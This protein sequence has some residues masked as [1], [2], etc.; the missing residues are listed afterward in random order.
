M[1]ILLTYIF[2]LSFISNI[3]SDDLL[4]YSQI[5]NQVLFNFIHSQVS[6]L[7]GKR[8]Q[9]SAPNIER[10]V[11]VNE[12][13]II[14]KAIPKDLYISF[15]EDLN[16]ADKSDFR[17]LTIPSSWE[18]FSP[19][20][21]R[22]AIL[23]WTMGS[24]FYPYY[25]NDNIVKQ[26]LSL[27]E[28]ALFLRPEQ[29]NVIS[30]LQQV[31]E[32]NQK[33]ALVVAPTSFGKSLVYYDH[34]RM[35]LKEQN[36]LVH[37]LSSD[38]IG[39]VQ[40]MDHSIRELVKLYP[41]TKIVRWYGQQNRD[42][43]KLETHLKKYDNVILLTTTTSFKN[44][45]LKEKNKRAELI[46]HL[47]SWIYDEAHHLGGNQT[48]E[49]SHK[50]FSEIHTD[51]FFT[52]GISASPLHNKK[53]IGE[54]Y[55]N[56]GEVISAYLDLSDYDNMA[57]ALIDQLE[58]GM[59]KA[60]LPLLD[61]LYTFDLGQLNEFG[62]AYTKGR[63]GFFEI[64][65]DYYPHL[66]NYIN[67]VLE[68][69]KTLIT[70]NSIDEVDELSKYF[71][72]HVSGVVKLHSNMSEEQKSLAMNRI[73]KGDYQL[74]FSVNMLNESI[75]INGLR[76]L[77][78]FSQSKSPVKLIHRL[79]RLLRPDL[80]KTAVR[81]HSF[82]NFD[83]LELEESLEIYRAI[84]DKLIHSN[85][86][87]KNERNRPRF[88]KSLK[89]KDLEVALK[90]LWDRRQSD[91][92]KNLFEFASRNELPRAIKKIAKEM[93]PEENKSHKT[94]QTLLQRFKKAQNKEQLLQDEDLKLLENQ[95]S[96]YFKD[97]I[98]PWWDSLNSNAF[99]ENLLEF[100]SRNE[101]PRQIKKIAKEM[102]L[103]EKKSHNTYQTLLRRFKKAQN[104]EQLL[105]DPDLKLL[106][107]QYP[108]Y[109]KNLI[110]PWWDSLNKCSHATDIL[111]E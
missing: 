95:Y 86:F 54:V 38:Y 87:L 47:G 85:P 40:T 42:S 24:E 10:S 8:L 96:E 64:N 20:Q 88:T 6:P 4:P 41:K 77:V 2:F 61:E 1:K 19:E 75:N 101:L 93:T 30:K 29:K 32:N 76:N 65:T 34:L 5:Q 22:S 17:T 18:L 12:E 35:R 43:L 16:V 79:G 14:I 27:N 33:G 25:A 63:S 84:G 107:Q 91:F 56:L 9:F 7:V 73:K 39:T 72:Q 97:L 80:G 67:E 103:E 90:S 66:L 46:N 111:S 55:E 109:F 15:G 108:E 110:L 69:G 92:R 21:L 28:P 48:F 26:R 57:L 58:V 83:I 62:P 51:H 70:C 13:G 104:K 68:D 3:Y 71:N 44:Y 98:L 49:L 36:S 23:S 60:E 45:I 31:Y 74:I 11:L 82:L 106:E 105:L 59:K 81:V 100:A 52:I 50:L 78:D 53:A 94:Y 99:Q 37:V 89:I 102:T